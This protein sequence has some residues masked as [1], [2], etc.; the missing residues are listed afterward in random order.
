MTKRC[1]SL[2]IL[3]LILG[4]GASAFAQGTGHQEANTRSADSMTKESD[5]HRLLELMG[6]GKIGEQMGTQMFSSLRTAVPNIPEKVWQDLMAEF[7]DEFSAEK[8]INLSIPIYSKHFTASE[9]KELIAFYESPLGR[10]MTGEMPAIAQEAYVAGE[11]QGHEIVKRVLDKLR[12]K[13]YPV[14]IA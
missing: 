10:K 3:P 12:A 4:A 8:I 1:F 6:V 2:V 7:Q 11:R 9:I 5:V 14:P 13:G